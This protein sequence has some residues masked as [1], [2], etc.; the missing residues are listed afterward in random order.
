MS[1]EVLQVMTQKA[2]E[3]KDIRSHSS[4]CTCDGR[5]KS[6]LQIAAVVISGRTFVLGGARFLG[7]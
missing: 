2:R 3:G 6:M 5:T 1:G 4:V 7:K